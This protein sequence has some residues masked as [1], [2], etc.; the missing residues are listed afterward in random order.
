MFSVSGVMLHRDALG[1][2]DDGA[3]LGLV[4]REHSSL[5]FDLFENRIE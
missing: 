5:L 1:I 2:R 4:N 3:I